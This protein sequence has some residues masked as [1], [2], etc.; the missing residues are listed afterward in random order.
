ML[1]AI[2]LAVLLLPLN[3]DA[4]SLVTVRNRHVI[5]KDDTVVPIDLELR[6]FKLRIGTRGEHPEHQVMP[7][8]SGSDADPT[9]AGASGGGA[10]LTVY[11]ASGSGEQFTVVLPAERWFRS[12]IDPLRPVKYY[13]YSGG[14]TTVRR[15][16]VRQDKLFIRARGSGWGYTLDEQLQG[17]V[18]V[19]LTLGT[20]LTYCAE[21]IARVP[22]SIYDYPGYFVGFMDTAPAV[23][24]SLPAP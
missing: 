5:L 9:A 24:P 8:A 21:A 6:Y 14:A 2:L 13:V 10:T 20:G 22:A 15:I 12:P 16:Y 11:N 4:D 19:R 3:V 17:R 7:P 23:C 1:P 18:A